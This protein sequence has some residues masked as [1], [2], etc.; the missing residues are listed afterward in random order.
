M[1]LQATRLIT[2]Q[3]GLITRRQALAAGFDDRDLRRLVSSGAWIRLR[4]GVYVDRELWVSLDPYRA[5]PLLRVRAARLVLRCQ[6]VVSHDS[7]AIAHGIGVP[8]PVRALVHVTRKKVHGDAVRTGVKHH[9]APY[10]E[11][12]VR[13]VDGL[14][15][16]DLA[17]TAL[18]L[19]R[20]HGL[21][22]GVAACDQVLRRGVTHQDLLNA[23]GAMW[24]WPHSRVM[25]EAIEMADSGS[26]SWLESE[27]RV[28]VTQL[29]IGRPETQFGLT[30]GTRTVYCDLRI[31]RH[32][33]EIDGMSKYDESGKRPREVL[34]DEKARQDFVTGF[35]LGVTRLTAYDLRAGR[36]AAEARALREYADTCARFGTGIADLTPYLAPPR[37]L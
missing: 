24:C 6:H 35:K 13:I 5:Q 31:G 33:F 27:G 30:D 26:E 7:A 17:R 11:G 25:D 34:A 14:P 18:D 10:G 2:D 3:H 16:L 1:L 23:R 29:G 12:Q 15:V 21:V 8:D 37:W 19:A 32:V 9:L 4:R 20:E 22:A 28:F 36:R